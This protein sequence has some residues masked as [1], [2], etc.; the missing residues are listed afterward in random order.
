M[1][2]VLCECCIMLGVLFPKVLLM[3]QV[4]GVLKEVMTSLQQTSLEKTLLAWCRQTT[5]VR[6][7]FLSVY[8][9]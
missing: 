6:A 5:Q 1:L 3:L 8:V 4:Q 9:R 2:G 7:V